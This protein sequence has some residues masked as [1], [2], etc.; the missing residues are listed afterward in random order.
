[1]RP[2]GVCPCL[3][4]LLEIWKKVLE[5]TEEVA[6]A[7]MNVSEMLTSKIAEEMRQQRRLKEQAF[8]RVREG[9]GLN[10]EGGSGWDGMKRPF[11]SP[12][13]VTVS[14][15]CFIVENCAS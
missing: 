6:K 3:R 11:Q 13:H 15:G 4:G 1:M 7:R 10:W 12:V 2:F 14:L 8:K 5:K 9:G